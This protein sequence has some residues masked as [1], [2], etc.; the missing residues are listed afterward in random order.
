MEFINHHSDFKVLVEVKSRSLTMYPFEF[1]F[2]TTKGGETVVAKYDGSSFSGCSKVDDNHIIVPFDNH[3]L[4]TGRLKCRQ[5]TF[6]PDSDYPDGVKNEVTEIAFDIELV[7]GPS[8]TVD[9]ISAVISQTILKPVKGADYFTPEDVEEFTDKIGRLLLADASYMQS[10]ANKIA[11]NQSFIDDVA[12]S[13][14][15]METFANAI[16][17]KLAASSQFASSVAPIVESQA[18]PTIISELKANE[19]FIV[20]VANKVADKLN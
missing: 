2:F 9:P 7:C 1:T 10:V 8:S 19:T 17:N 20:A 11:S 18:T 15:A 14:V 3:Q 6:I 5:E 13:I 16:T 12:T 4:S